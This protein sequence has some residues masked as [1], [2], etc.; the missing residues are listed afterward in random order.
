M[1]LR[2][3]PDVQPGAIEGLRDDLGLSR[4]ELA[5][6]LGVSPTSIR[7]IER[8]DS[9]PVGVETR[10]ILKRLEAIRDVALDVYTPEGVRL[11]LRSPL[12]RYDDRT[13]LE[14]IEDGRI[15]EVYGEVCADYEG[16]GF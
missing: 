16:L 12:P 2:R 4:D 14:L 15:A 13:P 10:A 6:L 11:F 8:S 7:K 1:A 9:Y 5:R 3:S